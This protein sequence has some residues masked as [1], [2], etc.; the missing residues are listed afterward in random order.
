MQRLDLPGIDDGLAV[1]AQFSDKSCLS[2]EA[3]L[4]V[5]IGEY[6]VQRG[7]AGGTGRIEDHAPGEQQF[8]AVAAGGFQVGHVVLGAQC[9]TDQPITGLGDLHGV[10]HAPGAFDGG[11]HAGTAYGDTGLTLYAGDLPLAVDHVLCAVGFGQAHHMH[12][13]AHHRLQ[14]LHT[15]TAG[16]VID[17]HHRLLGA[18]MQGFQGMIHQKPG[19][20]LFGIGD[21]V[22]QVEH[23]GVRAVDVGVPDHTGVVARYEHHAAAQAILLIH[24][25]A[26]PTHSRGSLPHASGRW[27]PVPGR[28]SPVPPC[29]RR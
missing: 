3:F 18:E 11:H 29:P 22:L 27:T 28:C 19:R 12:A 14:I 21:A 7:N 23:D 4:D 5:D 9:D 24:P 26:P 17:A 8:N 16:Q 2:N 13:G 10:Q 25:A 20:I 15:Q 1:E 6:G